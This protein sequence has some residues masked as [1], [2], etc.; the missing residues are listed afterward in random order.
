MMAAE[1]KKMLKIL[2]LLRN[3]IWL[4]HCYD[5]GIRKTLVHAIMY[6]K[7]STSTMGH[8]LKLPL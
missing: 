4:T 6:V 7:Q 2:L 3:N 5:S 1:E 8:I